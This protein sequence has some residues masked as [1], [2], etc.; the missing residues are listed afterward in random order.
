MQRNQNNLKIT[1]Y[2]IWGPKINVKWTIN[3]T[4]DNIFQLPDLSDTARFCFH[5]IISG[6][7][8]IPSIEDL[9]A[10]IDIARSNNKGFRRLAILSLFRQPIVIE[11]HESS[12]MYFKNKM[13]DKNMFMVK[14]QAYNRM[15][16]KYYLIKKTNRIL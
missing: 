6:L 8:N 15:F 4:N 9:T 10:A 16:P 11:K 2:A 12:K 3:V 5:S 14:I 7:E 13:I 1:Q